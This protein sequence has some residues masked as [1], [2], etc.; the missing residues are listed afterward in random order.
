MRTGTARCLGSPEVS[1]EPSLPA[2]P[3]GGCGGLV[4]VP[5]LSVSCRVP[6]LRPP[7]VPLCQRPLPQQ[8]S[9]GVRW[10]V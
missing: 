5:M 9:V 1:V 2:G 4:A 10:G 6:D 3:W 7:R 8:Q